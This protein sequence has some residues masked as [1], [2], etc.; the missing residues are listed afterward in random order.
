LQVAI[1]FDIPIE[2][3]RNWAVYNGRAGKNRIPQK[4]Y[5]FEMSEKGLFAGRIQNKVIFSHLKITNREAPFLN[6]WLVLT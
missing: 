3:L 2:T 6:V 4:S 1:L 5:G